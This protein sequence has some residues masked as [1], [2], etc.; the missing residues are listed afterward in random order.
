VCYDN[1]L[2][3]LRKIRT[4]VDREKAA[5]GPTANMNAPRAVTTTQIPSNPGSL[6]FEQMRNDILN[7]KSLLEK[8]STPFRGREPHNIAAPCRSYN[9]AP[10]AALHNAQDP[11][12]YSSDAMTES[13]SRS[14]FANLTDLQIKRQKMV[15]KLPKVDPKGLQWRAFFALYNETRDLFTSAEN[16]ARITEALNDATSVKDIGGQSLFLLDSFEIAMQ[17]VDKIAGVAD[18]GME[19]N[20]M[21]L[22]K[23]R[24]LTLLLTRVANIGKL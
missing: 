11:I 4:T 3:R 5:S 8:Q 14:S 7:L 12:N 19:M 2:E 10:S 9:L 17:R 22:L 15:R 18:Y 1:L 21:E 16:L 23:N 24:N 6:E 13:R 20:R